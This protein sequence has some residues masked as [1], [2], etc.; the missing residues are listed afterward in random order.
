MKNS[1]AFL[2]IAKDAAL[3]SGLLL[4]ENFSC[5]HAASF[6]SEHDIGLEIDK[7]SEDIVLSILKKEFPSHNIYSEEVGFINNNS[8]YTWYV[9]PLDGT[10]NYF[11]GIAYFGVSIALKHN[12]EIIVGVVYNPITDQLFTA[13]KG[14]GAFLNGERIIPSSIDE[15]NRAVLSFIRGHRTFDGG[16]LEKIS[17]ELENYLPRHFRRTLKMW[18]P[19]LDWCLLASGG[20]DAL[21]SFES[22][23]ED[24]YAGTLIALE[25]GANVVGFDGSKYDTTMLRIAGSAPRIKDELIRLLE[26]YRDES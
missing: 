21:V 5:K 16:P 14:K 23:L 20:I 2:Q 26:N 9:D 11:A 12:D 18:A 15:L 17:E 7:Q 19:S 8:E 6:K 3:K 24:Q 13:V 4:K 25:S 10:N 22:E 1:S